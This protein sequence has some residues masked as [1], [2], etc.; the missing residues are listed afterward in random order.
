MTSKS[1]SV[2]TLEDSVTTTTIMQK[3]TEAITFWG[4]TTLT[5][6]SEI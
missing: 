3:I 6:T 4:I 2:L 1:I 5:M